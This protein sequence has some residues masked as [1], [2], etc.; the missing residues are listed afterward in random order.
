MLDAVTNNNDA[1][2]IRNKEFKK[3]GSVRQ[4]TGMLSS[5]EHSA[6][7]EAFVCTECGYLEEYVKAPAD[8]PWESLPLFRWV[9]K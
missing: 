4:K 7:V 9:K 5:E 1:T 6:E 2:R 3:L 8:V